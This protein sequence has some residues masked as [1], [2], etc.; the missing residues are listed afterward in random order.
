MEEFLELPNRNTEDYNSFQLG[1]YTELGWAS[2]RKNA[3]VLICVDEYRASRNELHTPFLGFKNALY[4]MAVGN[5]SLPLVDLGVL[6]R[7]NSLDDTYFAL[8]E[9]VK[10][11]IKLGAF[12]IIVGGSQDLILWQY[13]ALTLKEKPLN[14]TAIDYCI[15]YD[16]AEKN[17]L[18]DKN[19]INFLVK[20]ET[21]LLFQYTALGVQ[22]FYTPFKLMDALSQFD[23]EAVRLGELTQNLKESEPYFR[24]SDL[25][26][27]NLDAME[28]FNANDRITSLP[29]G[30]NSR[31]ICALSKFAGMS[32]QLKSI[33]FYN[34][35]ENEN[36]NLFQELMAQILW[37]LIEGKNI[38]YLIDKKKSANYIRYTVMME[39]KELVFYKDK[40][41]DKWWIAIVN[42]HQEETLIPCSAQ[43]YEKA[44]QNELPDRYWKN[45]KR[46]L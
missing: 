32:P 39:G 34:Y 29:N 10:E 27:F 28:S 46:F 4:N 41:I 1:H 6:R 2:V 8:N 38:E 26:S 21:Q 16:V 23:F 40:N 3:L 7:G 11:I 22:S 18:T 17:N 30:F 15:P 13:K 35:F 44:K 36:N 25:I 33:G 24:S 19:V 20:E 42:A 5:W 14:Y 31:E 9:L 12:P 45:L 37:Y 43:D